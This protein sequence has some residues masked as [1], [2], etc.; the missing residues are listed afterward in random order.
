M[1]LVNLN[2]ASVLFADQLVDQD[3]FSLWY[4][5]DQPKVEPFALYHFSIRVAE[6]KIKNL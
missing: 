1:D 2:E 4:E 3:P 5:V 6:I